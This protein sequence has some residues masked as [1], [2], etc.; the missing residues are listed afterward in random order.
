MRSVLIALWRSSNPLARALRASYRG[1][2]SFSL[3]LPRP[4]AAIWVLPFALVL[5]GWR[6][7]LRVLVV[8]PMLRSHAT[9]I[10]ARLRVGSHL[11]FTMGR[12]TL[13]IGS[14]VY[15]AGK[16]SFLF[17]WRDEPAVIRIGD[18]VYIGHNALLSAA[19]GIEIGD[20][21]LFS[22][23]VSILDSPGHPLDPT[24]RR[25]GTPPNDDEIRPVRIGRNVW[26]GLGVLVLPG[27]EIGDDSVI[28]AHSVVTGAIPSGV[29]AAGAPA[30][31][32]RPLTA[33]PDRERIEGSAP[34]AHRA[35]GDV[36]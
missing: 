12:G 21:C 33:A 9:R 19:R 7:C 31:V 35:I 30:R 8:E 34:V 18:H 17:A 27:A 3:P 4:L 32:I 20:H 25:Q 23:D 5:A 2:V 15:L 24:R 28:A 26:L 10:G 29:L 16:I 36:A 13:V 22:N 1:V 11:P 14:D 6:W